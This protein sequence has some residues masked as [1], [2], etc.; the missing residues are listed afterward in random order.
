MGIGRQTRPVAKQRFEP[1]EE[2]LV[3]RLGVGARQALVHM[4]MRIDESGQ[5]DMPV[6][7]EGLIDRASGLAATD[8]QFSD[9]AILDDKSAACAIGQAG[10]RIA[11]PQPHGTLHYWPSSSAIARLSPSMASFNNHFPFSTDDP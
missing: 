6:G 11:Y 1:G 5:H 7:I 9:L 4:M 10:K 3:D 8:D 2:F